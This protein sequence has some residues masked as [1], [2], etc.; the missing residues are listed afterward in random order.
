MIRGAGVPFANQRPAVVYLAR[1]ADKEPLTYFRRF[2]SSYKKFAAGTE[3]DLFIIFKGFRDHGE[4]RLGQAQFI[5]LPH[6][7]IYVDDE[8][9]DIGAYRAAA[10]QIPHDLLCFLNTNSE[11]LSRDWLRKLLVNFEQPFIGLAGATGSYE[12]LVALDT[13]FPRFPNIHIRSNAFIIR[14]GHVLQLFPNRIPDKKHAF[15]VES[16][17][18]SITRRLLEMGLSIIV[19]GQNGRGYPPQ[20]WPL[21]ETYRQSFQNNLLVHDNVTREFEKTP[22]SGK[23]ALSRRTWGQYLDQNPMLLL[24]D[25]LS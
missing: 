12:S 6:T 10:E 2:V 4:L 25:R 17:H 23:K 21:S 1:G 18:A 14:R 22:W 13:N 19:V 9:F 15:F 24:P 8:N 16:G 5:K 20:W 11:I 3:H 7:P